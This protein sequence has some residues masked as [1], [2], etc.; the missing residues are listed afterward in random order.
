MTVRRTQNSSIPASVPEPLT[1]IKDG[2]SNTLEGRSSQSKPGSK[3]V[4]ETSKGQAGLKAGASE[5]LMESFTGRGQ[6][7]GLKA[8]SNEVAVE[9]LKTRGEANIKGYED[10]LEVIKHYL[11]D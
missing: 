8:D 11:G 3:D 10:Q 6:A 4:F 7:N 9:T 1:N 2:T 5:V